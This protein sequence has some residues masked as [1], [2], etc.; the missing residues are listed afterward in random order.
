[1][2]GVGDERDRVAEAFESCL[3]TDAELAERGA[4]WEVGSDGLE[5]WLGPVRSPLAEWS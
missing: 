2:V 5:P 3:L 1:M 4:Y